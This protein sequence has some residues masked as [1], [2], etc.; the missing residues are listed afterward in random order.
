MLLHNLLLLNWS[1]W[2]GVTRTKETKNTV[3]TVT[4]KIGHNNAKDIENWDTQK[5]CQSFFKCCTIL[6]VFEMTKNNPRKA[7]D[8]LVFKQDQLPNKNSLTR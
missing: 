7:G 2:K 6:L 5:N 1:I 4:N 3:L 8:G